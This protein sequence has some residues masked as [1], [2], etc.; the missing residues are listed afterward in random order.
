M[1]EK[2]SG[3]IYILERPGR[4]DIKLHVSALKRVP[5]PTPAEAVAAA[6][7]HINELR[8]TTVPL[9]QTSSA[10]PEADHLEGPTSDQPFTAPA[11]QTASATQPTRVQ[12]AHMNPLVESASPLILAEDTRSVHTSSSAGNEPAAQ[13][14]TYPAA[15]FQ[16]FAAVTPLQRR[17]GRPTKEERARRT[18]ERR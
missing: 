9:L 15:D 14:D 12:S 3:D 16:D 6:Q 13:A 7:Q 2:C 4:D 8:G 1:R 18:D 10:L 11:P 17:R 5:Q